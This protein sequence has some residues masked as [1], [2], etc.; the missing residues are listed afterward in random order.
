MTTR[1]M[2][3]SD[4]FRDDFVCSLN[5][6]ERLL[7]I[8]LVVT[9]AD[10]QGRIQDRPRFILSDVFPDDENIPLEK[11]EA[12]MQTFARAGKIERYVSNGK[13]MIQI[14]KWWEYQSPSW[15]SPSKYPAPANWVDRIKI[16]VKDNK[17]HTKNW[18]NPGGY[19]V[20]TG[21]PTPVG[22]GIE[23]RREEE[24]EEER[25][26]Y[27]PSLVSSASAFQIFKAVTGWMA[28][29]SSE[30]VE[31]ENAIITLQSKYKGEELI[32]YLKQFFNAFKE[33]YPSSA[34]CFWLTD[35]AVTGNIP[36]PKSNGKKPKLWKD[37]DGN[38]VDDDGNVVTQEEVDRIY[39]KQ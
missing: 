9:C 25:K 20:P 16:H 27:I 6:F 13:K 2:I 8:G 29:P 18:E 34:R 5:W 36:N 28:Y 11:V 12:A 30:A 23:K 19:V 24:E 17:V 38:W 1:R 33:R 31:S 26:E 37:A 39:G 15:A 22:T 3:A 35:W 7:W 32:V 14:I 4:I 10:D 21:V